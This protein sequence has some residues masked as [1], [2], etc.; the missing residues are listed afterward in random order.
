MTA[1]DRLDPGI[2]EGLAGVRLA[3][4]RFL[5]FSEAALSQAGIT[6]QQYQAML[7][8]KVAEQSQIMVRE[9]SKQMMIQRNG[10]VQLIDRLEAA[11]LAIRIPSS[12]DKRSVLVALTDQGETLLETLARAHLGAMLE[13]EPLLIDSLTQLRKL[14][15]LA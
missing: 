8:I 11:H 15:E 1:S 14:A 5:S 13:N 10:A 6:S 7:V 3:M 12:T 4:R 2:F 9:L